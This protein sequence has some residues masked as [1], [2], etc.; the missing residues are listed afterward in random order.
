MIKLFYKTQRWFR[1]LF[2]MGL[3]LSFISCNKHK[4]DIYVLRNWL[5]KDHLMKISQCITGIERK[6]DANG[7]LSE[8]SKPSEKNFSK[9]HAL[10]AKLETLMRTIPSITKYP[11]AQQVLKEI[12]EI[13]TVRLQ[14]DIDNLLDGN[15]KQALEKAIKHLCQYVSS[16]I[17]P[18]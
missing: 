14:P 5:I 9:A 10:L 17:I 16:L 3:G 13:L 2:V 8:T 12:M 1:D 18:N 11:L 4:E 6:L 7:N 15:E